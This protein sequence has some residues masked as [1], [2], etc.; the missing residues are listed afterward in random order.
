VLEI[1][2]VCAAVCCDC[3]DGF[4]LLELVEVLVL[5]EWKGT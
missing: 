5:V 1:A 4:G 2:G 3:V